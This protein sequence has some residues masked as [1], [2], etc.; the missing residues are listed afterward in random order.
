M[1]NWPVMA[2][3]RVASCKGMA[4]SMLSS[5]RDPCHSR[6]LVSFQLAVAL[7]QQELD[8]AE[9][10]LV[11]VDI[12]V[13]FSSRKRLEGRSGPAWLQSRGSQAASV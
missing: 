2:L 7:P 4:F 8:G 9:I 1:A 3:H 10:L 12:L 11:H 13:E 6:R 5:T